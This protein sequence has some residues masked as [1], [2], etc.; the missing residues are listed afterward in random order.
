METK[1][2]AL[3]D[4]LITHSDE[5]IEDWYSLMPKSTEADYSL[6]GSIH[7]IN[8]L[9]KQF[10]EYLFLIANSLFQSEE[11]RDYIIKER[12]LSI[13][14]VRL[15]SGT[16][17]SNSINAAG[18][19][20]RVIWKYTQKFIDITSL[21]ITFKDIF[22]WEE[23][24][25]STIDQLT[26]SYTENYT[27]ILIKRIHSQSNLI[28]E[29]SSPVIKLTENIGLLPIVGDI[30]STRARAINESTLQQ[31]ADNQI[32][33]LIIDLSGVFIVD[34]LVAHRLFQMIE[35][36]KLIG[37][38]VIMTG[39]RAEVAQ[40]SIQLGIDFSCIQT[41]SSVNQAFTKLGIIIKEQ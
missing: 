41:E 38:E 35:A 9:K 21:D 5:I 34:T 16:P 37:V 17:L 11:E 3:Y 24:F 26:H 19:L 25:N 2:K 33:K 1:S 27:N 12:T 22:F 23:K 28:N 8:A 7:T 6:N 39:I 10:K 20:R 36:L 30:D 29:L 40:T 32:S 18:L 14:E 15:E 13:A 4:Y 31:S